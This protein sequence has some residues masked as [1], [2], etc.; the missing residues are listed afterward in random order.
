M[1]F[2]RTKVQKKFGSLD[3]NDLNGY[4]MLALS[5]MLNSLAETMVY[6]EIADKTIANKLLESV[7]TDTKN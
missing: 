7:G 2:D 6:E 5:K 3:V 4:E 1:S